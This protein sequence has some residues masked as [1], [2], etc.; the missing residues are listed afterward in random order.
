MTIVPYLVAESM[1]QEIEIALN[2]SELQNTSL[3]E[4]VQLESVMGLLETCLVRQLK[5]G[6]VLLYS[7]K[8]NHYLYLLLSGQ[9]DVHLKLELD[10][11]AVLEPGE[12]V[13]ELSVIDRQ[14]TSAHVVAGE[15][16][17]VMQFDETTLWCLVEAS[18]HVARNLLFVLSR[19][20]RH[21]NKVILKSQKLQQEYQRYA[22]IDALTGV[23]NRR[24]LDEMLTRQLKRFKSG[25]GL[26]SL[27]LI[28]VDSFKSYNDTHGHVA[29]DRALHTIAVTLGSTTR[30]GDMIA[31]YGGDE[32]VVLLPGIDVSSSRKMGQ[33]LIQT[34][35]TAEIQSLD[36]NPLPPVTISIGAAQMN[37]TDTPESFVAG[38]DT[39]LYRA[40][41]GGGNLVNIR[42][43]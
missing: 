13:G 24:W 5:Q 28:D 19:R 39:A 23:F 40:K 2:K 20:L 18:H 22:T 1:E 12:V 15:D 14:K 42:E 17:R 32:F 30:P 6:E 4:G 29:A 10:P 27:L 7:G 34:I 31:R 37:P 9:L 26:F 21:G 25:G 16:S 36:G 41:Q 43:L 11:I 8:E 33:R 3:L 35:G 38:A